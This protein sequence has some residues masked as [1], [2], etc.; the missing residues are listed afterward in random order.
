MQKYRQA[1]MEGFRFNEDEMIDKLK[2]QSLYLKKNFKQI[3]PDVRTQ[4]KQASK[5]LSTYNDRIYQCS[6]DTQD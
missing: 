6:K 1:V 4:I 2:K 3:E 5:N